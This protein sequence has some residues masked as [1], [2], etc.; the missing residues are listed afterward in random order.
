MFWW[1]VLAYVLFSPLLG[2]V[3]GSGIR[4]LGSDDHVGVVERASVRPPC[5]AVVAAGRRRPLTARY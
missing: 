5:P 1:A 2:L 4:M 3:I